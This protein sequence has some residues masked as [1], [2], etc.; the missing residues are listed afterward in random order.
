M[1]TA[2]GLQFWGDVHFFQGYRIQQNILTGHY[3]LL[4]HDNN[5]KEFGSLESCQEKLELIKRRANL[6]EMQ[7]KAVILVHGILRT[8]NS[9]NAMKIRLQDEGYLTFGFGYPSTRI[10]ITEAAEYLHQCIHSLDGIS[11][12]NLVVHSMGGLVVRSMLSQGSDP[13]FGRMVM[14][15]TPNNGAVPADVLKQNPIFKGLFGPAGQQLGTDKDGLIP[16]LPVP[17]FEF[18]ILAG[19]KGDEKGFNP[20]LK[21]DDDGTVSVE[22]SRLDGAAD[23]IRMPVLHSFLMQN[24]DCIDAAVSF[25]KTGRFNSAD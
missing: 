7:G 19:G 3:R 10:T 22:S 21:G 5:R 17:D 6:C 8:A 18:G 2:G 12:I 13:R 1:K 4:D 11:E 16:Q 9:F 20:L 15:G 24:D 25:L 23:F 14:M